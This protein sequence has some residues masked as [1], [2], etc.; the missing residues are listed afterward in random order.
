MNYLKNIAFLSI[1]SITLIIGKVVANDPEQMAREIYAGFLSQMDQGEEESKKLLKSLDPKHITLPDESF[2]KLSEQIIKDTKETKQ[3]GDCGEKRCKAKALNFKQPLQAQENSALLVFVT[4]SMPD[5][6]L[7]ALSREIEQV[8]GRVVIMGLI[9][10]SF[11]K[12]QKRLMDLQINVD[13]DPPLFEQ[14]EVNEVPTFIH[15]KTEQGDYSKTFD[16]LR[17]NVTL[18]YVLEQLSEQGTLPTKPLLD[19]LRSSS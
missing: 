11:P 18:T 12:T 7:R 19:K 5:E 10:N 14:F 16:R 4:L 13:I 6:A 9:D 3:K 17:G 2:F 1:L 15:V 8:G